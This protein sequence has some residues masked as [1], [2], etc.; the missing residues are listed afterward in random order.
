[1]LCCYLG[2]YKIAVKILV[3][4]FKSAH[5]YSPLQYSNRNSHHFYFFKVGLDPLFLMEFG[6]QPR[7]NF[8]KKIRQCISINRFFFFFFM[9]RLQ[10]S[11]FHEQ[12]CFVL[13]YSKSTLLL[14]SHGRYDWQFSF[15]CCFRNSGSFKI[16]EPGGSNS[17]RK[18]FNCAEGKWAVHQTGD[19]LFAFSD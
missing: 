6:K 9:F 17:S 10:K 4:F 14:K 19:L 11:N 13:K 12:I 18:N 5:T 7:P 2:F 3:L 16:N 8:Q 1:M 15:L